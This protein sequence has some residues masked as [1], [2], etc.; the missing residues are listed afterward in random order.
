[1]EQPSQ[2]DFWYAVNNTEVVLKPSQPLETFGTTTLHYHLVS[3]LMD[4][5]DQLRVRQGKI[6]AYRPSILTPDTLGQSLLE[7]FAEGE[8]ERYMDW[9][10]QHQDHLVI[11]QY[12]FKVKKETIDDEQITD[13]IDAVTERIRKDLEARDQPMTALVR[14][15]EEPW[16]VCLLK[17]LVEVVQQSAL[18]NAKSLRQDPMGHHHEIEQAFLAAARDRSKLESLASLLQQHNLFKQYEDRFFSLIR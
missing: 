18:A 3:A 11:L 15:V 5:V 12:G 1:M 7:G 13:N 14:G 8:A 2:F 16:E 9:L 10:R 6:H 17:L 4:S